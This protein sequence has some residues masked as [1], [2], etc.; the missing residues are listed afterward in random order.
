M[1][2]VYRHIT[3]A[4]DEYL[5]R[6]E[7]D[8]KVY[9][10]KFG[11]DRY[12]GRVDTETGLIYESRLGPDKL[13]GRVNQEDGKVYHSRMGPDEYLGKVDA[14][15]KCYWHKMMAPDIYMGKI[16]EM[17]SFAHGGAA[18]LLLIMPAIE[19]VKE[20]KEVKNAQEK[21]AEDAGPAPE[22]V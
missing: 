5:G 19:E 2:K 1:S 9:E 17:I 20:D 6:V 8:G 16:K 3:L 10:S 15:G 11:P 14:N 13:I 12:I 18:F 7:D 4:P 21:P 22:Q